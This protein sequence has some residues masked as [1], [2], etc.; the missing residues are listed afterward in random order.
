[1]YMSKSPHV[2]C[3]LLTVLCLLS[4]TLVA[5]AS[6][7]AS[8]S[9]SNKH[10]S[11]ST[12]SGPITYSTSPDDV[13][14]RTFRGG[15]NMGTL[16]TSPEISIYGDGAYIL[17]PGVY[18]QQGRLNSNELDR[19][20]HTL[21]DTY[22]L[23]GLNRQ[24][25]YDLPDQNATLLQ[26]TLNGK[27]YEYL[28]GQ[29]GNLQESA[30]DMDEYHRLGN[31]LASIAQALSGPLQTYNGTSMALLVHQ[32]F[33]P[34]LTQTIPSWTFPDFTLEQ[35]AAYECG[36]TPHDETGP[37]ADSGCLTFTVPHAAQLLTTQQLQQISLL[38]KGNR[39]GVFYEQGLYYTVAIR[40]LLPD[41]LPTRMLA[42]FGSRELSYITVPLH[43][44][45]V[46]ITTP[47]P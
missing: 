2:A 22:R 10:H 28:Y 26:L 18:M 38:L 32:V 41:E 5:C 15:G 12:N 9:G 4:M 21:V 25:F 6:P 29:F 31:A 27:H 13:L 3:Y 34:D 40:P 8:P 1:M 47:T 37:N 39:Q 24:Q 33:N 35:I 14:V 43:K 44:G 45:A 17:G 11:L 42:M 16:E 23:L 46:P 20:L 19:L 7:T 30:R 36:F